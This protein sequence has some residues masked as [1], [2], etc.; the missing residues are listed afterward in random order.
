MKGYLQ[1]SLALENLDDFI[2]SGAIHAHVPAADIRILSNVCR[3]SRA[4]PK[5][6]IFKVLNLKSS[7]L[8][9]SSR[10]KTRKIK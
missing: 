2:T 6:V 3:D 1:T 4:S 9:T 5:S 8:L 10:I 7:C